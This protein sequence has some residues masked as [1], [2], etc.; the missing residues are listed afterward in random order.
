MS[1]LSQLIR[2]LPAAR[3]A[4]SVFTKPGGGRYFNSSK[5]SKVVTQTPASKTKDTS[6]ST[7]VSSSST[8][9][10]A[11]VS[12]SPVVPENKSLVPMSLPL[13]NVPLP[14]HPPVNPQELKLH[15]FFSMHRPLLTVSQPVSSIFEPATH[16][17]T[18]PPA[19][20]AE[21]TS[22]GTIDDP[23]EA[24]PEADAD[25]ARQLARSFV[26]S[27]VGASLAWEDTLKRLG[28]DVTTGRAD[29]VNMAQAEFEMLMDSTKRKRRKKMKKHKLKK[30]RRL[31][32]AQR[33][34]IGR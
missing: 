32:R 33:L 15:Q 18:W 28:L 30:R 29:E 21:G 9:D 6:S 25:A 10:D 14:I 2:P 23:P 22:F 4:Y 12:Q 8:K 24:S 19:A 26:V 3:R 13:A 7:E 31:S 34:K 5:P 27:R 1:V 16:P 17:F 11:T 20:S